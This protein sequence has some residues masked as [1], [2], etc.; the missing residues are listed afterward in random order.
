MLSLTRTLELIVFIT[1]GGGGL[2]T[3]SYPNLVIPWTV[4]HP[5]PLFMGFPRQECWTGLPS[6]SP[7]NHPDPGIEP[8]SPA[9]QVNFFTI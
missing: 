5:A 4:A 7:R 1:D 2:V 6:P 9:L 8:V 3:K